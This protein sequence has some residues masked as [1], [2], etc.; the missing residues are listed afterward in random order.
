M[1]HKSHTF[2]VGV[3]GGIGSGKTTVTDLFHKLHGI[4]IIDADIIARE[5]VAPNSEG[6]ST[7]VTHFGS[8]ILLPDGRLNREKLRSIIFS[9]PDEK[10]W[11]DQLLHPMIRQHMI[12][13]TQAATSPYCL[14]VIPL[15][16]DNGLQYLV[17][18]ILVIDVDQQTQISRTANRDS[19]TM[20]QVK[21]ILS[22]QVS[23][24]ERLAF[25]DD[26]INN[27]GDNSELK[28]II[29]LLHEQYLALAA[30]FSENG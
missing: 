29:G 18:R 28:P 16:I 30:T 4:D 10:S 24:K 2:V 26:V 7:I 12:A 9:K 1:N 14:L 6:L 23:R 15:L 22:A 13:Q 3:T 27:N 5:V 25:A 8:D 17:D 21:S 20:D 11:L 19:V